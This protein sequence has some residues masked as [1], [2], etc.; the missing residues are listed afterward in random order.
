MDTGLENNIYW[1][2]HFHPL[3]HIGK[4][5]TLIF[6]QCWH[7]TQISSGIN[8]HF[9]T[10]NLHLI[11]YISNTASCL[12][13][14]CPLFTSNI[15]FFQLISNGI[16]FHNFAALKV[17]KWPSFVHFIFFYHQRF[18]VNAR[19]SLIFIWMKTS[20]KYDGIPC[21]NFMFFS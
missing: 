4:L 20:D 17:D 3:Q 18:C 14:I 5:H 2:I 13:K 9:L 10:S 15:S 12:S 21:D 16:S 7:C 19:S 1:F 8:A 6:N 11:V